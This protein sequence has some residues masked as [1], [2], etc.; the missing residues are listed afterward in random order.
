MKRYAIAV[1]IPLL[2]TLSCASKPPPS[3]APENTP[4]TAVSAAE[5]APPSQA[6]PASQPAPVEQ[7]PEAGFDA[8][9]ISH[10]VFETT[11]LE[12]QQLV[13]DLNKII[14]AGNYSSWLSYLGDDYRLKINS[15]EFLNDI[16]DRYPV[17]RG[18][19]N[20]AQDYFRNVVVP[21]R[22]NDHV[23][24]IEFVSN[25]EVKAYS[26]DSKGQTVVLYYLENLD[27]KWKIA[28]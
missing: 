25:N 2:V 18:R 1:M 22:T 11:K 9:S 28:N 10:E 19:I 5:E 26:A 12:I 13:E 7:N 4:P 20:T 24:D 23:D 16:V 27:G 17:F 15:K 3:P 14:R 21:S 8:S 6:A